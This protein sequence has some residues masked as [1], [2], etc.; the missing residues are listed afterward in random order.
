MIALAERRL[1]KAGFAG[2]L[3]ELA[4]DAPPGEGG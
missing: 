4:K 1:D 2:L 3:Q